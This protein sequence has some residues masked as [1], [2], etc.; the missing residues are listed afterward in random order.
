[1][2][3]SPRTLVKIDERILVEIKRIPELK[4]RSLAL[5]WSEKVMSN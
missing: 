4:P 1:M 3:G 5:I 2:R